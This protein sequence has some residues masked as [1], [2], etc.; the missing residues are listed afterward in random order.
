MKRRQVVSASLTLAVLGGLVAAPMAMAEN[1]WKTL[2]FP[3][4]Y[5]TPDSSGY[6]DLNGIRLFHAEWGQGDPVILLHGGLGSIEA[7]ANQIPALGGYRV[8]AIDSRGHGRSTRDATPYSY[9]LM[10]SD[11][12]ALMDEMNIPK[13]VFLGWSDGGIIALELA[14]NHPDRIAA[15]LVIGTNYSLDGIDPAVESNEVFG[16][17]VGRAADLYAANSPTPDG[18][19]AFVG[20]IVGMWGS[21]PNYSEAELMSV[22]AKFTVVQALEDEAIIDAH[23]EKMASLLP[24][25][26]YVPLDGVSHFAMWQDPARL[27]AEIKTFLSGL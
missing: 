1:L 25:A 16:E 8:I 14:I 4:T 18:F 21:Q 17:Y 2:P 22:T 11:V 10:A 23:A 9:T 26:T 19:D 3:T 13:A 12:L 6:S 20:D 27:N 15:A 5:P 24:G 7:W